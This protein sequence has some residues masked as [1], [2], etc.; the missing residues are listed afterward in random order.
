MGA[1]SIFRE[2][3]GLVQLQGLTLQGSNKITD[4]SIMHIASITSLRALHLVRHS[5]PHEN[6]QKLSKVLP[7]LCL[8]HQD[9]EEFSLYENQN[10][11][12]LVDESEG[13][14]TFLSGKTQQLLWHFLSLAM[15]SHLAEN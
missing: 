7:W 5:H 10:V 4:Q 8:L 13:V 12:K 11:P 15:P 1:G 2:L 6:E 3:T 14:D 9:S